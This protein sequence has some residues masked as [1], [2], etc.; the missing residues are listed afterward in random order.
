M[1]RA[2]LRR[3]FLL[4]L[5]SFTTVLAVAV[6]A[7]TPVP[8]TAADTADQQELVDRATKTFESF[9]TDPIMGWARDHVNDSKAILILPLVL[10]GAFIFGAAGGNGV[11]VVRD[12]ETGKWS[13]PAFYTMGE[14]SFGLQI[15]AQGSEILLM[16]RTGKGRS[17]FLSSSFK[18]G[19]DVQITAGPIGAGIGVKT[20]DIVAYARSKGFFGGVQIDGAVISTRDKWNSAYYGKRVLP[21][22]ILLLRSV[23]NSNADP[24]VE[25]VKNAS[26]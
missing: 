22:D 19:T 12:D 16:I 6:F 21:L 23:T 4:R 15:G 24:L 5:T 9:I 17:A 13:H 11:L 25:A 14:I 18:F 10:K 26:K 3:S 1:L 20:G 7:F 2:M 8:V